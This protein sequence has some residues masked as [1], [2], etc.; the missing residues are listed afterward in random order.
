MAL[1]LI[2]DSRRGET[3]EAEVAKQY[4]VDTMV[5]S[6]A[7]PTIQAAIQLSHNHPAEAVQDLEVTSRYELQRTALPPLIA[8][9]LRGQALLAMHQGHEAA[10]EFQK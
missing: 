2:G 3:I 5:N 7:L 1:A 4:P 6:Y 8:V 10:A 9:Y